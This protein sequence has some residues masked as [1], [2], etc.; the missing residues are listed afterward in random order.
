MWKYPVQRE[1]GPLCIHDAYTVYTTPVRP[2]VPELVWLNW[3]SSWMGS[4]F[5]VISFRIGLFWCAWP[6]TRLYGKIQMDW[7]PSSRRNS[8]ESVVANVLHVRLMLHMFRIHFILA[9][10]FILWWKQAIHVYLCA[11]ASLW[12]RSGAFI[13]TL[14]LVWGCGPGCRKKES[15]LGRE[16]CGCS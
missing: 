13:T 2:L 14:S 9:A 15:H 6:G 4:I 5:C 11:C 7:N 12:I 3:R 16:K 8:H 1:S 10:I